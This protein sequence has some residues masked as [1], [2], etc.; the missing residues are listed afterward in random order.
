[1]RVAMVHGPGS[2]RQDGVSDYVAHLVPALRQAG[3]DTVGVPVRPRAPDGW[4][5]ATVD[6]A[7]AVRRLRPD[8]V[9]VQF[10]PSAYRFS[11]LPGLLPLLVAGPPLVTTVHEY[12]WW[13]APGWLPGPLWRPVEALRLWD[14]ET[15]RLA[16]ASRAVVVTNPAHAA[17]VRHRTGRP[18]VQIPLAA[19]VTDAGATPDG[20]DRIRDRLGLPERSFLLVFFGFV[21]PV[22]GVRYL[23]EALPAILADRPDLHL[24]VAGG[25]TS[26]ALPE[27]EARAFRAELVAIA[28]RCGVGDAVTFTGY[29]PDA[30][31]SALLHAAD[32]AVL[33]FTAGVSGTS[34]ALLAA[35][36][37]GVPT[38]VTLPD[39]PEPE[40][41][42]GVTVA[43]IPGRR[44]A[45]AVAGTLRR[46]AADDALRGRLSRGGRDLVAGRTWPRI[47]A[48]HTALYERV[49]AGG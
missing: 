1:M 28:T 38:A 26:Q 29:L 16:P 25:F 44:D 47:A 42:D 35:L 13:A 2:R 31:V 23:L 15:G 49:L 4:L 5:A 6:A 32:A 27:A 22:K 8:V 21:H 12:G 17:L 3:A 7:R 24:V 36:G 33:P 20:R 41:R 37:H 46:L 48:A 40:L 10:A 34:G 19:N 30:E 43:V 45:A 9:H 18:P 39:D 11:P 14:R